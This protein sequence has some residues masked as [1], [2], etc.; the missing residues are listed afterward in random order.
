M[1]RHTRKDLTQTGI[2]TLENFVLP[3]GFPTFL[4]TGNQ[5]YQYPNK[6][7]LVVGGLDDPGNIMSAEY[8]FIH[9][10]EATQIPQATWEDLLTR[11]RNGV[12][13]YQ[14]IIA[15]CN[16][17][18]PEHWLLKWCE[19]GKAR[20][21]NFQ[22]SDNPVFWDHANNCLT[23]R[24]VEYMATLSTL[25]GA[26]RKRNVLGLWASEEGAVYEDV[27]EPRKHMIKRRK[28]SDEYPRIWS[29]D[30]GFKAP[31]CVQQ[32]VYDEDAE[33]VGREEPGLL[34]LEKQ[35][36]HSHM[37]VKDVCKKFLKKHFHDD[38]MMIIVDHQAQEIE[39]FEEEMDMNCTLASKHVED[40]IQRMTERLY[41]SEE[42][43]AEVE[44]GMLFMED[45]LVHD[46]D[47]YLKKRNKPTSTE[48][49][50]NSYVWDKPDRHD[51]VPEKPK[52]A[53]DHGMDPARYL[54]VQVDVIGVSD[55]LY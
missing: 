35:V 20:M 30:F 54:C 52:K 36:Y 38:P 27:W 33:V 8:D 4:H 42:P 22:I 2:K 13:P 43:G 19:S 6:S 16:P 12:V 34:L 14:Q 15:D 18:H 50:F 48:A 9:I 5:S 26:K 39:I 10:M 41:W 37:K 21:Y 25:T 47:P 40:G 31:M 11:K 7:E 23:P 3:A 46:V 55:G 45:S 1:V 17:S 44:P 32:W 29:V 28:Y 51:M 49:E 24:G 53:N